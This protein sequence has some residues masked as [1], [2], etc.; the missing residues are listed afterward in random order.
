MG[1]YGVVV[2]I[3][4][5]VELPLGVYYLVV[6]YEIRSQFGSVE[7]RQTFKDSRVAEAKYISGV[8]MIC[9]SDEWEE[10]GIYY[11]FSDGRLH[12]IERYNSY[13]GYLK[14]GE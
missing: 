8:N 14:A 10:V 2:P 12:L 11:A 13:S 4:R 3:V 1:K 5:G 7:R 6:T 9:A